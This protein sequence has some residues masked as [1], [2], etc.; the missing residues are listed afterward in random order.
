LDNGKEGLRNSHPRVDPQLRALEEENER[1]KRIVAKQAL[2]LEVKSELQK[3]S[4][5][6]QEKIEIMS[7]YQ[8]HTSRKELCK[9]LELPRSL[10]YYKP[11]HG[12]P[13]AKA[14]QVTMKL[15]DAFVPNEDVVHRIKRLIDTEFNA[16]GYEY[17]AHELKKEYVI[18]KKKAA[19]AQC[20]DSCQ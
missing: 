15:D 20:I 3:N 17:A 9:W 18:N 5:R 6:T 10:S 16:F 14:S 8:Q 7:H 13:G 19:A 4:Y 11:R 12:K 1:L 2:E